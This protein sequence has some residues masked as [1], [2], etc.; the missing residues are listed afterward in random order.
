MMKN[1]EGSFVDI[2]GLENEQLRNEQLDKLKEAIVSDKKHLK[3]KSSKRM[4]KLQKN[5][6]IHGESLKV[7]YDRIEEAL[8]DDRCKSLKHELCM[9]D[10][11]YR[12][13]SRTFD[14][15]G[16]IFVRGV[17]VLAICLTLNIKR[18]YFT[19]EISKKTPILKTGYFTIDVNS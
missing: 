9:N 10:S 13:K 11:F 17:Y 2:M 12:R 8:E 1:F 18:E 14:K 19:G 15:D 16:K 4:T 6:N 3:N 7:I 5:P